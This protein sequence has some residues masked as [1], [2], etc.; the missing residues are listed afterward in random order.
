[1]RRFLRGTRGRLTLASTAIL[2]LALLVADLTIIGALAYTQRNASDALL[3]AQADVT[4]AGIEESNGV[5]SL[6]AGEATIEA[7]GGAAIERALVGPAG[8][9]LRSPAEALPAAALLSIA[10]DARAKGRIWVDIIDTRGSSRRVIAQP[11]DT[12]ANAPVLTLSRSVGELNAT[13]GRTALLLGLVSVALVLAGGGLAYWLAGQALRP[14][15]QIT[16]LARTL[17]GHDLHRRVAIAVP[18]DEL[19]DLVDT[20]NEMLGRLEASFESLR[21]FTA[22]ASHELRAPLA[23][24]RSELDVTLAHDRSGPE[25]R[26]TLEG[27]RDEVDHLGRLADQLLVLAR[28]DAGALVPRREA[29]DLDD[30]LQ[31]TAAR[32]SIAASAAGVRIDVAAEDAGA[33]AAEPALLRRI[34][35]NLVENALRYAPAGTAVTLTAGHGPGVHWV[36]VRDHGP[37]IAA[38]YRPM[39]FARFA[40]PDAA[41]T[42]GDGGAGLGLALSAAIAAAHG[43]RVE[44]RTSGLAPGADFRVTVPDA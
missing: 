7:P 31:E 8:V 41:R 32:W 3:A 36:G 34:I 25:Y 4:V 10:A 6:G 26:H 23:L 29:V 42:G 12:A 2:A 44:L 13:L 27:L 28:A 22:D 15:R 9:L 35:D 14:V 19:G 1:M 11:I 33:A 24:L 37:G 20:F 40:R 21:R 17:G 39:L 38:E 43:G 16:S 5:Y 30:L 18:P